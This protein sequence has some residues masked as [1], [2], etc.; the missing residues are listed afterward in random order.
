MIAPSAATIHQQGWVAAAKLPPIAPV[1]NPPATRRGRHAEGAPDLPGGRCH[2]GGD[3]GLGRGH[4]RD[5]R[6]ADRRVDHAGTE[7]VD[8][9]G[10]KQVAGRS[11]RGEA[12]QHQGAHGH[13]QPGQHERGPRA[14]R[15]GE[16]TGDGGGHED[17]R[18]HREHVEARV[19]RGEMAD[20]LEVER[21]QEQKP[22]RAGERTHRR[23]RWRR[24]TA[25]SRRSAFSSSGSARR[26]S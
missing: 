1:I 9:V 23:S 3:A 24:R 26:S 2:R 21:V 22:A 16:W 5:R 12:G 19:E 10:Q 11:V 13:R 15:A 4:P 14:A 20:L 17:H 25:R 6:V 7:P 18:R 8:E